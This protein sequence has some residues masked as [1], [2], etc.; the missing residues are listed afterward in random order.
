MKKTIKI[1]VIRD[2][3]CSLGFAAYLHP[4]L[5]RDGEAQV[6]LNIEATFHACVDHDINPKEFL[7]ENI[8]HEVGHA[9][10]EYLDLEFNEDRIEE[11]IAK[12]RKR[13][14]KEL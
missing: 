3:S 9:M 10:E 12:Y 14:G 7:I 11:I 2:D 13:Y 6:L 5:T 1:K 8:M 4:S